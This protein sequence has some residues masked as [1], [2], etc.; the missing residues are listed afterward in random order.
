MSKTR[1]ER[2]RRKYDNARGTVVSI[3]IFVMALAFFFVSM[4]RALAISALP[5]L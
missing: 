4:T 1:E 2:R 3:M 5:V